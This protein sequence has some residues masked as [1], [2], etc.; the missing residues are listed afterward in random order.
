MSVDLSFYVGPYLECKYRIVDVVSQVRTCPN[1]GCQEHGSRLSDKFCRI[2]GSEVQDNVEVTSQAPSVDWWDFTEAIGETLSQADPEEHIANR[3]ANCHLFIPNVVVDFCIHEGGDS[4]DKV[5][6]LDWSDTNRL[7]EAF[8][9][10]FSQEI[11]EA[12]QQYDTVVVRF[13]VMVYR[14]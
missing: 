1:P 3:P 8:T 7:S 14:S 6:Q 2:C 5:E 4:E 12:G 11:A 9:V 13:G 10:L